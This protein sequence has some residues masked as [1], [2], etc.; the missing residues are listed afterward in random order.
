M[1][2][3][4]LMLASAIAA[5]AGPIV[6]TTYPAGTVPETIAAV[7]AGFGSMSGYLVVDPTISS[8]PDAP[9]NILNVNGGTVTTVGTNPQS[10]RSGIFLP[11]SFGS[12]GGDFAVAGFNGNAPVGIDTSNPNGGIYLYSANGSSLS[13]PTTFYNANGF[14]VSS[15]LVAP[16]GF[17]SLSGDL[18]A[19]YIGTSNFGIA[20]FSPDGTRLTDLEQSLTIAPFGLAVAPSTFG[21]FANQIIYTS[22]TNGEIDAVDAN[23]NVTVVTT[24]ATNGE[25]LRFDGFAPS[26]FGQYAGDLV[27]D[28]A[29]TSLSTNDGYLA[30]INASGALVG[31]LT[32]INPRGFTFSTDGATMILNNAD[33]EVL[34]AVPADVTAVP[35]PASIA[36]AAAG[37][38]ALVLFKR[39]VH[40]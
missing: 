16:S 6:F 30:F 27:V 23:G 26:G 36:L 14:S 8:T 20:V 9:S 35:E 5:T 39:R 2:S 38:T 32:G 4:F 1:R 13:G 31:E 34:T 19:G 22:D 18:L 11:S 3:I 17:G 24:L 33:P 7:P 28:V 40:F 10:L 29:G 37:L 25:A 21:A 12:V 15:I